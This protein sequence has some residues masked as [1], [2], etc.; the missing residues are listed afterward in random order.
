MKRLFLTFL[1][2]TSCLAI[3]VTSCDRGKPYWELRDIYLDYYN[4]N[5]GQPLE[6]NS[7][8]LILG[9]NCGL[10][11]LATTINSSDNGLFFNSCYAM[12]PPT[13]GYKGSKDPIRKIKLYSDNMISGYA[14]NTDLSPITRTTTIKNGS[15]LYPGLNPEMINEEFDQ[16]TRDY[17]G[18]VPLIITERPIAGT[19]HVFTIELETKSGKIFTSQTDTITWN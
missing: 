3:I 6:N 5:S 16:G 13:Q 11:Y 19:K 8:S 12:Q 17:S 10:N 7:D 1:L 9:L 14:P 18:H 15:R 2:S 4:Y